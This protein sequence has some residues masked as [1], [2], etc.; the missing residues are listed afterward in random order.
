M[1]KKGTGFGGPTI[2]TKHPKGSTIKR[3]ADGT[4][5]VV[6]PKKSSSKKGKK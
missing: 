1:A 6:P 5:T 3:N 2:G 4:I